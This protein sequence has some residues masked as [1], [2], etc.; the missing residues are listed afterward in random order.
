MFTDYNSFITEALRKNRIPEYYHIN[1]YKWV[2]G[3][4]DVYQD[5]LYLTG[6]EFSSMV[7]PFGKVYGAFSL[8]MNYLLTS[9]KNGPTHVYGD[10]GASELPK[11]KSLKFCPVYVKGKFQINGNPQLPRTI[12]DY[13][14]CII[15][16]GFGRKIYDDPDD[17]KE[18]PLVWDMV[19]ETTIGHEKEFMELVHDKVLF[20]QHI[21]RLNPGLIKY[22]RTIAQPKKITMI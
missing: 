19:W 5:V 3:R 9:L 7:L 6:R 14:L 17:I 2:D 4:L 10:F 20:H 18:R 16:E 15:G 12:E 8:R 21:M 11:L 13:P 22:Y 1:N